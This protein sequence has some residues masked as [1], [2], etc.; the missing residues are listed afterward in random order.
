MEVRDATLHNLKHV[1][2]DIPLG[3]ITVVTG[4]AGSGKFSLIRDVFAKQHEEQVVLIDQSAITATGRSTVC[5][6]LGFLMRYERFLGWRTKWKKQIPSLRSIYE[7]LWVLGKMPIKKSEK[8]M[9]I[10]KEKA[11]KNS[12]EVRGVGRNTQKLVEIQERDNR[13]RHL[14][15][16]T[17]CRYT[18]YRFVINYQKKIKYVGVNVN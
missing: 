11:Q 12:F 1:D 13:L 2:V 16:V 6:F 9:Q 15:F 3:I 7:R 18:W 4:V 17:Y 10:R 5:T 8:Y 14:K